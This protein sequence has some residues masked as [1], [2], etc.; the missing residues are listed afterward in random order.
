MDLGLIEYALW[1][2]IGLWATLFVG[3]PIAKAAGLLLIILAVLRALT[4]KGAGERGK[5]AAAAAE[6]AAEAVGDEPATQADRS[7]QASG[8]AGEAEAGQADQAVRTR[9]RR[10]IL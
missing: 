10:R 2:T 7:G 3:N 1:V 9:P 8:A 4:E 6:G 5:A